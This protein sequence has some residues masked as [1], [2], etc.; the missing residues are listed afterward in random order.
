MPKLSP[1]LGSCVFFCLAPG[2]VAGLVPW[3]LTGWRMQPPLLGLPGVRVLGA[4]LV[5]VGLAA[6]VACVARFAT[7]GRGTPAPIAPTETLVL[8]GLYR[9]V[10]NPMYVAVVSIIVG[11]A[12]VFG[13]AL[14]LGYAAAVWLLFQGF[15]MLYEEPT[16]RR[17]HGPAYDEYRA[18][19][20]R[21]WP[22][23]HP[24]QG[25]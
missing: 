6:L 12:L 21:W 24:W 23:L 19:V 1:I 11:Q 16:L 13:S 5:V 8:S 14:V 18:H 7:E 9:H 2:T 10:R 4:L 22:R 17:E 25:L 15:T 3:L 20:R